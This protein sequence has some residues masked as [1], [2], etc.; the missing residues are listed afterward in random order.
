MSLSSRVWEPADVVRRCA[1]AGFLLAGF[2]PPLCA[3]ASRSDL[4]ALITKHAQ[5]NGVPEAL[6]RRVIQRESGYNPHAVGKGG[7]FGLMQI[8]H[9]TARGMGY[10][11]EPSGLLDPD[12]NLTFAVRYLAGAYRAANGNA[13]QAVSYFSRGYYDAAKRQRLDAN[14]DRIF[15][16]KSVSTLSGAAATKS[17]SAAAHPPAATPIIPVNAEASDERT[18]GPKESD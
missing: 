15:P 5:A 14:V 8:K 10:A 12:T 1:L 13:D 18:G 3:E 4:D 9:A 2:S 6:V 17:A 7:T 16:A 11:G